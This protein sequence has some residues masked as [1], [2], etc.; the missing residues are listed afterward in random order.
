M[1]A[2]FSICNSCKIDRKKVVIYIT[3]QY[4]AQARLVHIIRQHSMV[5]VFVEM[6]VVGCIRACTPQKVQETR[7]VSTKQVEM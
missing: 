6:V 5:L 2:S 7:G 1:V 4:V 3:L